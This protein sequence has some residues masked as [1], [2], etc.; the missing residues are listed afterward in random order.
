MRHPRHAVRVLAVGSVLAT[1]HLA[2]VDRVV[3]RLLAVTHEISEDLAE[4][5]TAEAVDDEVDW[6]VDDDEQVADALVVEEGAGAA[7][8]TVAE[9]RQQDLRRRGR[10]LADDEHDNDDNQHER[11]VILG[12]RW[13]RLHVEDLHPFAFRLPQGRDQLAVEK[14]ESDEGTEE[15]DETVENVRVN[16]LVGAVHAETRQHDPVRRQVG[17]VGVFDGRELVLEEPRQIVEDGECTH[18]DDVTLR[19]GQRAE[20]ERLVRSTHGHVAVQRDENRQ[21]DGGGLSRQRTRPTVPPEVGKGGHQATQLARV[22]VHRRQHTQDEYGDEEQSIGEL[23]RDQEERRRR[24]GAIAPQTQ[25]RQRIAGEAE[26]AQRAHQH[27]LNE[28]VV[29]ETLVGALSQHVYRLRLVGTAG[30]RC[31]RVGDP[32]HESR[33]CRHVHGDNHL[34][35]TLPLN[36][37]TD[38]DHCQFGTLASHPPTTQR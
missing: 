7:A 35:T 28:E 15:K 30:P 32:G 26:Q 14:D 22:R 3:W 5:A 33:H 9:E 29:G 21:V 19:V 37:Q 24:L 4:P 2:L 23:E 18:D 11:D 27:R 36:L 12:P 8:Q 13:R 1:T 38:T 17:G 10:R 34:S 31:R 6:R 25:H 16:D 20:L